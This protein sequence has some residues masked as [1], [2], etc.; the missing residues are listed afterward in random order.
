MRK[1]NLILITLCIVA[2]VATLLLLG[3]CKN[4]QEKLTSDKQA[5]TVFKITQAT[6]HM[7]VSGKLGHYDSTEA[8]TDEL[9]QYLPTI[10][11][12]NYNEIAECWPTEQAT[13]DFGE[14]FNISDIKTGAQLGFGSIEGFKN[15]HT[16]GLI[17][18]DGTAI[19]LV[20]NTNYKGLTPTDRLKSKEIDLPYGKDKTMLYKEY[21]TN[22]TNSIAF[23]M[24]L[25]GNIRSFNRAELIYE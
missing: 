23:I 4:I 19:I 20:Y 3:M 22:S 13:N 6:N 16:T 15:S 25:N 18:A 5:V 8:F 10:K 11:R 2:T 21:T 14:V 12:C 17:L 9:Q 7:K 24:N 1:I